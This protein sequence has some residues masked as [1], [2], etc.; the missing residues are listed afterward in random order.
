[1][2]IEARRILDAAGFQATRIVAS[3]DLDEQTIASLKEQGASIAVWGVGT[4]LVTGHDNP[5]LG[6]V[7]KLSAVRRPGE[8]W[9]YRVKLSEQAAKVSTP[10]YIRATELLGD[11]IYDEGLGCD[12]RAIVDPLDPTR[13]KR[14]PSD[15][16][17]TDLLVPVMRAGKP[18]YESPPL[19]QIRD[20]ARSQV[21]SLSSGVK[22]FLNAHQYPVGLDPALHELK[23]R[24][25]LEARKA[26]AR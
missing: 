6:G 20:R 25:V 2:S 14:F 11:A 16:E 17:Q 13:S 8:P 12:A 1:L 21:A 9:Q 18:V 22:R 3:N 23:T 7:Y 24:L 5:A 19:T 15:A 4:R 10:G 26:V